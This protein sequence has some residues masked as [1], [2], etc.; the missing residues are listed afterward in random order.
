MLFYGMGIVAGVFSYAFLD[1][2]FLNFGRRAAGSFRAVWAGRT[3]SGEVYGS[4]K[5]KAALFQS[6]DWCKR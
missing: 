5:R 1:L 6:G 3:E 4:G 2:L